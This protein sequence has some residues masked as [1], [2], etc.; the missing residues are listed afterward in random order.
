MGQ[1]ISG[2]LGG[3]ETGTTTSAVDMAVGTQ[4]IFGLDDLI[5]AIIS[6]PVA[7]LGLLGA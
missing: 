2:L 4:N 5:V 3:S 6:Q 1:V 7:W